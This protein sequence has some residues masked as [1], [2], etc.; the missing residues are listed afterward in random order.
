MQ[1]AGES[2]R[3][4]YEGPLTGLVGGD[5]VPKIPCRQWK[6][7]D[8]V[9]GEESGSHFRG[10]YLNVSVLLIYVI[11]AGRSPKAGK[12]EKMGVSAFSV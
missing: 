8:T 11:C 10:K 7:P 12:M 4:A 9:G 3:V 1:R 5:V 6:K 2:A